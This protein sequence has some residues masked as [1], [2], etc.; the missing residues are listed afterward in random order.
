MLGGLALSSRFSIFHYA[1]F[2]SYAFFADAADDAMMRMRGL[3]VRG[4]IWVGVTAVVATSVA[5]LA[6]ILVQGPQDPRA[7]LGP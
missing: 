7:I 6:Q 1:I 2:G 4:A 3:M 5:A